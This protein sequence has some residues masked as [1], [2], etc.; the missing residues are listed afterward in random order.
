MSLRKEKRKKLNDP[1]KRYLRNGGKITVL[2]GCELKPRPERSTV[3][4]ITAGYALDYQ[5]NGLINWANGSRT[6]KPRRTF[7]SEVT[8]I[9][10]KRIRS[11]L[12]SGKPARL[13]KSEYKRLMDAKAQVEKLEEHGE[14]RIKQKE[15]AA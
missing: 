11:C 6:K 15:R 4:S 2:P 14:I 10:L 1:V 3:E 5:V 8:G 12:T 13:T 7:L 9:N